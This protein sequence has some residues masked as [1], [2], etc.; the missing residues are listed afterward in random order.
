ML[1]DSA[2]MLF[3]EFRTCVISLR[4]KSRLTISLNFTPPRIWLLKVLS[5]TSLIHPPIQIPFPFSA[6]DHTANCLPPL[7]LVP[8]GVQVLDYSEIRIQKS[9]NAVLRTSLLV[10]LQLS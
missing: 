3:L 7:R 4:V 10:F 1:I 8:H 9:V 2:R 5:Y 6:Q